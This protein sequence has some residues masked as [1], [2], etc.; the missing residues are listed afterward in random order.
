VKAPFVTIKLSRE[1]L[2][3]LQDALWA[4]TSSPAGPR[5]HAAAAADDLRRRLLR[6]ELEAA[7]WATTQN[8]GS[9]PPPE[10]T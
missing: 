7:G 8:P 2:E 6:Q 9:A 4:W 1:E 10:S 5:Y 3:C